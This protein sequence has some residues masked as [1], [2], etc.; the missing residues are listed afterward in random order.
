MTEAAVEAPAPPKKTRVIL[1]DFYLAGASSAYIALLKPDEG[2]TVEE[3]ADRWVLNHVARPEQ[4]AG[5]VTTIFKAHVTVLQRNEREVD[6]APAHYVPQE[7]REKTEKRR[8]KSAGET[9]N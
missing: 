1:L 7:H 4:T 9:V 2:D 6:E 5:Q 3:L 8:K